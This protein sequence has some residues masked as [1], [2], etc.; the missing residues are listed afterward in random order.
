MG[1]AFFMYNSIQ[2]FAEKETIELEKIIMGYIRDE[3][4][5][6]GD[7]VMDLEKSVHKLVRDMIKETLEDIDGIFRQSQERKKSHYIEKN[8]EKNTILTSCGEVT[9]TRTYFRDRKENTCVYLADQAMGITPNM[10]KSEDVTIKALE[11]ACDSSYRISGENATH[12]DDIIS[13][14]TVMKEI[15]KL[16]IPWVIPEVEEKKKQRVLYITADEDHVSLQFNK[17]KGDLV[18]GG[19]GYKSNTLEPKLAVLFEG[20][21]KEG[22]NSKRNRLIGKYHFGGV[23]QKGEDLWTEVNEYIEACY[24]QDYLEKIYILGDGAGWIKAGRHV[25]GSKCK[26]V[27][28]AFHLTKYIK[29]ATGHLGDSINDARDAIYDAISFEDKDQIKQILKVAEDFAE[30]ESKKEAV[31]MA[32]R[33]ILNHWESIIIKNEDEDARMGSS[34]EGQVSH[35]YAARMSSRPM[36]WSKQGADKMARLRVFKANGGK[37]IDLFKYKEEKE[38]RQVKE[39]LRKKMDQEIKS[40]RKTFLEVW[41]KQTVAMAIGKRTTMYKLSQQLR[42]IPG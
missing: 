39:E 33:Y 16:D 29:K 3:S 27:L 31:R 6:L 12:T 35:L 36:G 11:N 41:D 1:G 14:Q 10:R 34:A 25:L 22:P 17:E 8:E 32:K 40:K 37:V 38:K 9:Y 4:R 20:I 7:L 26:F 42:G 2:H 23:Y 15:H 13:K 19:N 28:D 30:G 5:N 18:K 24:D 21:E